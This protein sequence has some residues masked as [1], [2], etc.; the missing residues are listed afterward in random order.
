MASETSPRV[1]AL[2]CASLAAISTCIGVVYKASQVSSGGFKYSTTS[3][4]TI[5][6][7]VKLV[8]AVFFHSFDP[9][10]RS[11]H[12]GAGRMSSAWMSAKE[13]LS[14]T[15]VANIWVLSALYTFNNQLSFFAYTMVD[16]GTVFL[17]KAASTLI[18][19]T[20]Q[21]LFA[22]KSFSVD[23][24]RAMAIQ[25]CGLI[26]VQYDPCKSK[27]IHQPLAYAC[28]IVSALITGTC[29]ARNE[30]LVKNYKIGL[31]VQNATLYSGGF[32][33]NLAAFFLVPNP[34]SA[35]AKLGFFDGY[36]NPL[37]IAVV[38]ANALI[39]LAINAVYKYADA[40]TKCIAGDITA[41]ALCVISSFAF[42]LETSVV[43]WCGIA[44][45]CLAVHQYSSAP[46]A[47]DAKRVQA[48]GC[49]ESSSKKD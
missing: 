34:N 22:G 38:V 42:G 18:V 11:L 12:V 14:F 35:Q 7:F 8:L 28:L 44:I 20:V 31:N 26:V 48:P 16:P 9:S 24:W 27:A 25:A 32:L 19:A 5:A 36:D 2:A 17:F 15:A 33:M 4:I 23:Q 47:A 40:V 30:H 1:K 45:V 21:T 39:G 41:I 6:E 13:Q 46:K 49:A 43:T 29:A 3:A 10:H 37:A